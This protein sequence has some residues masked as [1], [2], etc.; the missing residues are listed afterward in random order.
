MRFPLQP[1]QN[2]CV[3]G[4]QHW[5]CQESSTQSQYSGCCSVD[6]CHNGGICPPENQPPAIDMSTTTTTT[7]ARTISTRATTSQ[8][9][10]PT[11]TTN[12]TTSTGVTTSGSATPTPNNTPAADQTP[13]PTDST[14]GS[15]SSDSATTGGVVAGVVAGVLVLALLLIGFLLIRRKRRRGGHGEDP[16]YGP[17]YSDKPSG[18]SPP[19]SLLYPVNLCSLG[20][21]GL[22]SLGRNNENRNSMA[23]A[24]TTTHHNFFSFKKRPIPLGP[25]P[26]NRKGTGTQLPQPEIG[27]MPSP[28]FPPPRANADLPHD[29]A[30]LESD[31]APSELS[32]TPQAGYRGSGVGSMWSPTPELPSDVSFSS[33]A[34]VLSPQRETHYS[35]ASS[36][37]TGSRVSGSSQS[38]SQ[39]VHDAP[40]R[41][42][43]WPTMRSNMHSLRRPVP[44]QNLHE[45]QGNLGVGG[46]NEQTQSEQGSTPQPPQP[47]QP[48]PPPPPPPTTS[49]H[50][51]SWMSY[52][53]GDQSTLRPGGVVR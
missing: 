27:E 23:S 20:I 12:T 13:A 32:S 47:P 53:A 15:G 4:F 42:G 2:S 22:F 40:L 11:P 28:S 41:G 5:T 26:A 9:T 3:A 18:T 44:N 17:V 19:Y 52:D 1:R 30:E 16:P 25:H 37:Q 31:S 24:S 38:G 6:A 50:V 34:A 10:T 51:L 7:S 8:T 39:G 14:S 43:G 49:R 45:V 48:P 46:Q 35:E 29:R 33:T 21:L 36:S